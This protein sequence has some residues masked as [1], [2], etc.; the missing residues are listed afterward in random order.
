MF[1]RAI[2]ILL[3]VLFA[4]TV[5]AKRFAGKQLRI[6][7]RVG[8]E[9]SATND[10]QIDLPLLEAGETFD[11]ELFLVD[12]HTNRT[13]DI[14]IAFDNTNNKFGDFFQIEKIKGIL[15]QHDRPGPTTISA[16]ADFPVVIPPNDYL[17]TVTLTVKR[18]VLPGLTLGFNAARTYIMDEQSWA[19]DRLDVSQATIFFGRP[20]YDLRLDLNTAPGNQNLLEFSG[21]KSS[22]EIALQIFGERI[23][24]MN[25]FIFRFE[26]DTTQLTFTDFEAGDALPSVQTIAPLQTQLDSPFADVEVTAASFGR[27]AQVENGLLGTLKFTPTELFTTTG[28]RMTSAEVRRSGEFRPFF[29]PLVVSLSS[30]NA[31]FNNDGF[32]DFRDFVLF[33]ERFGA[34]EGDTLYEPQFDLTPDGTI[35]L[36]D[37]LLFT[38]SLTLFTITVLN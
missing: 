8:A 28:I 17:A 13:R 26:Y 24:F 9:L 3:L 31:D 4:H 32:V 10:S 7:T 30:L 23:K 15:P 35:N 21:I 33:A 16:C 25:G 27:T 14:T 36:A 6:D 37:F 5:C 11:I 12:G 38:E 20:D 18:A 34:Q 2:P 19:R 29:A 22:T 1:Y